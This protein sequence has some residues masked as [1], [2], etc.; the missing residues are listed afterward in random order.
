MWGGHPG[1]KTAGDGSGWSLLVWCPV[2]GLAASRRLWGDS[3]SLEPLKIRGGVGDSWW[4]RPWPRAGP[5]P[6]PVLVQSAGAPVSRNK[7]MIGAFLGVHPGDAELSKPRA[8]VWSLIPDTHGRN[9]RGT[10]VFLSKFLP[11]VP[12]SPAR[13]SPGSTCVGE[14]P[15]VPRAP[16]SFP[17]P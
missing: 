12:D 11:E 7:V 16:A 4:P 9:T 15:A 2:L 1:P 10:F 6:G 17:A 5:A 3:P 8:A 14:V 13:D